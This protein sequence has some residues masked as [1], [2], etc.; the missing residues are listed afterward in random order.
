M[1]LPTSPVTLLLST[2]QRNISGPQLDIVKRYGPLL[3]CHSAE[4]TLS[5]YQ[6]F[7]ATSRNASLIL[8]LDAD[9]PSEP[10]QAQ[11]RASDSLHIIRTIR[12]EWND[13]DTFI[14]ALIDS[15]APTEGVAALNAGANDLMEKPVSDSALKSRLEGASRQVNLLFRLRRH[16]EHAEQEVQMV[17]A[18][19][20][21]LLPTRSPF[22]P[23]IRVESLY[24]ASEQASGDYFDYFALP[25][26]R[27]LRMVI[28]D[29]AGHGARAAFIM[30]MVC[31]LFRVT[32]SRSMTL[33]ETMS[34][35]SRNL[36]D[37][38]GP[39]EDFV[40]L[41]CADLL[42]DRKMLYYANAGHC[43]G[44]LLKQDGTVHSLR[45]TTPPMGLDTTEPPVHSLP[46]THGDS[47]FLYTDGFF[48]WPMENGEPFTFAMFWDHA[49][50]TLRRGPYPGGFMD[51]L[52]HSLP[53]KQRPN[54]A[55]R[56]D[57]TALLVDSA[58]ACLLPT[59]KTPSPREPHS[60]HF[61]ALSTVDACKNMTK[62]ALAVLREYLHDDTVLHS[63]HLILA[64]ATA[65][66]IKHAYADTEPGKV[67]IALEIIPEREVTTYV[68][69]WGKGLGDTP[70]Q[71][72]PTP[73]P[74]DAEFGRGLFII[75]SLVTHFA[76]TEGEGKTTMHARMRIA[77]ESWKQ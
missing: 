35:V 44:M 76:L 45:A 11:R 75:S 29:V 54:V 63:L 47:L 27:A 7:R 52:L 57:V 67:E 3:I 25:G 65:N 39:Q 74:A 6:A 64:E 40:T 2:P 24:L 46:M 10:V 48:D 49:V 23:G 12:R 72:P 8:L 58:P 20:R 68:T 34:M 61:S 42:P 31:T 60:Y 26:D 14:I 19:Q 13:T 17:A 30:G 21:S 43:P 73:A 22:I 77:R 59:V 5:T 1:N 56:D 38:I 37:I 53:R 4:G 50:H 69:D 33:A 15:D 41:L 28:A 51:T 55:F 36:L 66:S 18:L 9:I 32:K 62:A 71:M 70:P 16:A